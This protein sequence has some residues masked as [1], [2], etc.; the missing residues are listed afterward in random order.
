MKVSDLV[1]FLEHEDPGLRGAAAKL[2][3][4]VLRG[5]CL[6]SGGKPE[7]WFDGREQ[8]QLE[9][10][11]LMTDLLADQSSV[12]VRQVI[13]GARLALP[14]L[15]QSSER[16]GTA[17]LL[18]HLANLTSNYWPFNVEICELLSGIDC[19]AASY[20]VPSW[21]H[22]VTDALCKLLSQEDA[23]VR[24]GAAKGLVK[25][26]SALSVKSIPITVFASEREARSH[27]LGFEVT[28][29]N[30]EVNTNLKKP[31]PR[32]DSS[33]FLV[34]S[35]VFNLLRT[36]SK[37]QLTNGCFE[38]LSLLA[39]DHS[40]LEH[41]SDWGIHLP[42]SRRPSAQ[43]LSPLACP[44]VSIFS[45]TLK[46]MTFSLLCQVSTHTSLL[47]LSGSLYSGLVAQNL[48]EVPESSREGVVVLVGNAS[49]LAEQVD[50]LL[51]HLIKLLSIYTKCCYN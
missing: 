43:T 27:F 21:P 18:G 11:I 2:V 13:V 29:S 17:R 4:R 45:K 48:R 15:I 25:I 20:I 9:L 19:L 3:F 24:E 47:S 38:F 50:V 7:R 40:S 6:E 51:L 28:G 16:V 37:K 30:T 14:A 1:A 10:L 8:N 41:P 5:A 33:F 36:A 22:S 31:A 26:A 39:E 35:R 49:V 44:A 34:F 12:T 23:R 32:R 42:R 46:F